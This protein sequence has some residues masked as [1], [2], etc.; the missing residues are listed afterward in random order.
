M[1]LRIRQLR[2]K[3][4]GQAL[5]ELALLLPVLIIFLFGIIEFGRVFNAYLVVT[6][7]SREGVRAGVVGATDAEITQRINDSTGILNQ[8]NLTVTI[9]PNTTQR[10]RGAPLIV[11]VDYQVPI[12]A[13]VI[14]SVL[15]NP[16]PISSR[17]VMRIE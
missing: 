9:S 8:Q 1:L 4:G 2:K 15:Q 7:A 10:D 16:F 11:Q 6:H 3:Q 13:P 14:G 5:V 17:T 12:Y